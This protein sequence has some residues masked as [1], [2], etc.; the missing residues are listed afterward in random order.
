MSARR[1]DAGSTRSTKTFCSNTIDFALGGAEALED[2]AHGT[3]EIRPIDRH[4][5]RLHIRDARHPVAVLVGPVEPE[6]RTPV[7]QNEYHPLTEVEFVPQCEQVLTLFGVVVTIGS[8]VV[9][10]VGAAHADQVA[11]DESAQPL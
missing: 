11:R 4:R 9:E 7:V 10:L 2:V 3:G 6:R 5:N 1:T 8:G